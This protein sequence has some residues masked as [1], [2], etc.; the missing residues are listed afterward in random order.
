MIIG[1]D[2]VLLSAAVG[3]RVDELVGDG[4]R[5]LM[6]EILNDTDHL[7]DSGEVDATRLA[8]AGGTPPFL[9][10]RRVVV[11]RGVGRFSNK[12]VY[13]PLVALIGSLIDTTDLVLVWEKPNN[14]HTGN[15]E[16][17]PFPAL[18]KAVKEAIEL[19]GGSVA[20]T[21]I[22]RGAK[23]SAW[24]GDQLSESSLVFDRAAV[25]AAEDLLGEDRSR[26][27]GLLRTLEGV[28]GV[29]AS[30]TA[31]DI[32]TYG[33]EEGSV[34]PWDLEDPIDRGDVAAAIKVAHRM[35]PLAGT[36][37]DRTNASFKLV[38]TLQRRYS[39][40]LRLDGSDARDATQAAAMMGM[41]GSTYPAKKIL[42]QS[43]RL[44]HDGI[45][46]SVR[47]L[48][49][50]DLDLRGTVNWPPELVVEVLVARLANIARRS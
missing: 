46:E 43:R 39:G 50:A 26:V 2:P 30:V 7:D 1:D 27:V 25:S 11:G 37:S 8:V 10:E 16:T 49:N 38:S 24:L 32:R 14:P 48:A 19:A 9:T 22:P 12:S 6:L 28:L 3:A 44:G 13:L 33:G 34:A 40:M 29:G 35:I 18:P 42:N 31:D 47:L 21:R 23:A 36:V 20:D 45:V 4:D 17:G 5:S 15:P 41:K